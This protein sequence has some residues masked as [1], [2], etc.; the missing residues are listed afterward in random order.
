VQ[1][2]RLIEEAQLREE[3]KPDSGLEEGGDVALR[4][5]KEGKARTL[6]SVTVSGA[7]QVMMS[8]RTL[9]K[10]ADRQ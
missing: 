4:G 8:R 1:F 2:C 7:R 10:Q 3:S 9:R 5:K 6:P